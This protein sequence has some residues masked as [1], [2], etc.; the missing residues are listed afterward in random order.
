LLLT[1]TTK[2]GRVSS[3]TRSAAP[4]DLHQPLLLLLFDITS[5]GL[6]SNS[7]S[8]YFP[9]VA[10]PHLF[11]TQALWDFTWQPGYR[12]GSLLRRSA[13]PL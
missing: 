4:A 3:S 10:R 2:F 5:F 7:T 1:Y 6:I 12:L 8:E 13:D 11:V 9:S